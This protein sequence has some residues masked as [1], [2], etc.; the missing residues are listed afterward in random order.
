MSR[1]TRKRKQY[2]DT[3]VTLRLNR[4]IE[5]ERRAV[6]VLEDW[7]SRKNPEDGKFFTSRHVLTLALNALGDVGY[8]EEE[9]VDVHEMADQ[10]SEQFQDVDTLAQ[11]LTTALNQVESLVAQLETLG[12]VPPRKPKKPQA[13]EEGS[14]SMAFMR[15]L[16]KSAMRKGDED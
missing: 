7:M 15:N 3:I 4:G 11:R 16:A 8:E 1:V 6:E 14:P 9:S 12:V 10:L 2:E 13:E 5:K